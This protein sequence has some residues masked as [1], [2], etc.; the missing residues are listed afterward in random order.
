[1]CGSL[2]FSEV[3]GVCALCAVLVSAHPDVP[4]DGR[5]RDRPAAPRRAPALL[6]AALLAAGLGVSTYHYLLE[7]TIIFAGSSFCRS[8]RLLHNAVDQLVRLCHDSFLALTAFLI[9]TIMSDHCPDS[10][11]AGRPWMKKATR[12]AC[13]WLP[14]AVRWSPCWR[15][16]PCS[17]SPG[18]QDRQWRPPRKAPVRHGGRDARPA[19]DQRGRGR[20]PS[21][22]RR[23]LARGRAA[24]LPI[25]RRLS[26]R[27]CRG[28]RQPGQPT[29][30]APISSQQLTDAELLA[31]IREGRDLSHPDNT[32][33]LVMPP[34]GGRP[35]LSDEDLLGDHC[36]HP[37]AVVSTAP[38]LY[39]TT[40]D[41][42]RSKFSTNLLRACAAAL[43]LLLTL[44][45]GNAAPRTGRA[46]ITSPA[47]GSPP[48]SATCRSSAAR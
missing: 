19:G 41:S 42:Q 13:Q 28:R 35:D 20:M 47:P 17:L 26:W 29:C 25:V 2:Y 45:P 21:A 38:K 9:I 10:T 8:G 33:G 40:T 5:H 3:R 24:L 27:G 36:V 22:T 18:V 16:S 11:A 43:L 31:V 37:L 1:M 32:T 30:A 7:K 15:S 39:A 4:A 14:S 46:G 6:R 23:L 44:L 34:S 12:C 48:L